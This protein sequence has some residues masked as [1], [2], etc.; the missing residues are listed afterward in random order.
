MGIIGGIISSFFQGTFGLGGLFSAHLRDCL[1]H[2]DA[3]ERGKAISA[4]ARHR[5]GAVLL[6][7]AAFAQ[8]L[9]PIQVAESLGFFKRCGVLYGAGAFTNG[10][11]TGGLIGGGLDRALDTLG[12]V[13]VLLATGIISIVMATGKSFF[14]A[15]WGC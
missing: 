15:L 13:I 2:L 10:G 5:G 8:V 9:H 7:V 4:C 14:H 6:T 1:L 12:S 11:L 3:G